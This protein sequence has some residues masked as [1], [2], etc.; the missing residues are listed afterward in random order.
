MQITEWNGKKLRGYRAIFIDRLT[1]KEEKSGYIVHLYPSEVIP[2]QIEQSTVKTV[3][4]YE[5]V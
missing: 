5:E 4:M 2:K 1:G 3:V